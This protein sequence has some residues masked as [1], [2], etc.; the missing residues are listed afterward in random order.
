VP[1]NIE[2]LPHKDIEVD[3]INSGEFILFVFRSQASIF[4]RKTDI[5]G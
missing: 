3:T 2:S 1:D 4:L 5:L